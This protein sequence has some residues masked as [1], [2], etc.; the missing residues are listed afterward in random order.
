[1]TGIDAR[2]GL[3]IGGAVLLAVTS[4]CTSSPAAAPAASP[5]SPAVAVAGSPP[6]WTEPAKYG[7]VVDRQCA[8]GPSLGRYRVSVENG[9]V[10]KA[11]RIDGR[12]AEGEE[13]IEVPSLGGLL[14][15]ARTAADD[16]GAVS[17]TVD[18][19]DGHPTAVSFDVSDDAQT[20]GPS[21][22]AISAYAPAS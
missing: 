13:E 11:D 6:S 21:C 17:T 5:A 2:L 10:V 9:Q 22:F 3:A 7:F 8:G 12:T 1:V 19:K 18:P 16:G 15:L 14:E 20:D 4:G